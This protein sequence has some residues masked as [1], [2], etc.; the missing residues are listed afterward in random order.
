MTAVANVAA[1]FSLL[2][3]FTF[4]ATFIQAGYV[5]ALY[6]F[7]GAGGLLALAWFAMTGRQ[8]LTLEA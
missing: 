2:T 1:A 8:F 3:L 7:G 4:V 5:V 6:L